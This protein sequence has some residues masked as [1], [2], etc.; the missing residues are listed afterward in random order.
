MS[1]LA[2]MA[3]IEEE[4]ALNQTLLQS[5]L[6]TLD[7]D[8]RYVEQKRETLNEFLDAEK[9]RLE[10]RKRDL[11]DEFAERDAA[12]LRVIEGDPKPAQEQP[13]AEAA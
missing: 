4:R 9:A 1:L 13:E 5:L 7:L 12:L 2:I 8:L 11:A 10:Q 3:R 6:A